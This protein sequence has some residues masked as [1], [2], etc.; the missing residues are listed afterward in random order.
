MLEENK[1]LARRWFDEVINGRRP[2]AVDEL[3]A[4]TY[5]H[6][7]NLG[8]AMRREEVKQFAAAILA[9]YP[10]RQAAVEDMVAED[11]RVVVRWSSSGTRQGVFMGHPP[12]GK[13]ETA[14]GI[15]ITRIKDGLAVEGWEIV[16]FGP[17]EPS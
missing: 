5:I 1:A 7:G 6:H 10:D 14:T 11:D 9:A 13:R 15:W 3:F 8:D 12:S 17:A 4:P 2:E 16:D